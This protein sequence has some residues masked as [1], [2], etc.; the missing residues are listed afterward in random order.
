MNTK[1]QN[2]PI[3]HLIIKGL[4]LTSVCVFWPFG[5]NYDLFGQQQ[6]HIYVI[7]IILVSNRMIEKK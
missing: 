2:G 5:L 7:S 4:F 1:I 3:N 6:M